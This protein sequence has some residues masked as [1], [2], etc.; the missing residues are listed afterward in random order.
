MSWR[1][2]QGSGARLAYFITF[3]KRTKRLPINVQ[4]NLLFHQNTLTLSSDNKFT[5][6]A[7]Q[8]PTLSETVLQRYHVSAICHW[9]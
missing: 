3:V 8:T 2:E 9:N 7:L 5:I 1:L 4:I 6:S